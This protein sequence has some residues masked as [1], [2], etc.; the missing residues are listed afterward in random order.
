MLLNQVRDVFPMPCVTWSECSGTT[1]FVRV[2]RF[3]Y[4]DRLECLLN[5]ISVDRVCHN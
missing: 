4:I 1:L 2:I 5:C 3:H